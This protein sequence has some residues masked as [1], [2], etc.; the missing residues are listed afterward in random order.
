MPKIINFKTGFMLVKLL[1]F[2]KEEE[3]FKVFEIYFFELFDNKK[4]KFEII[5]K[6][7]S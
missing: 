3:K 7:A 4:K 2:L 6:L 1:R 5:C